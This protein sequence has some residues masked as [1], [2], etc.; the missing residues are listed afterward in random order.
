MTIPPAHALL[1][2]YD[3]H[4][5]TLPWRL[6]DRQTGD[7][8]GTHA[9][10]PYRVW[11]SEI[12][13]QQTT[14]K[15]VIPYYEKF[16]A[17]FPT[18]QALA[19]ADREQV[20][21]AWAGLG[22]YSR[23]RNLHA[24][25]QAV[26]ARGGFPTTVAG[27]QALPGIGAYTAAAVAAI[28]FGVPVVPVDGNVERVTARLFNMADP[29]P[30]ARRTLATLAAG[31]NADPQARARP[32]AFAQALFD[33]GASLCSPRQ[34][35]CGLCPW[36]A[37]CAAHAAGTAASLPRKAPKVARPVRYGVHFLAMDAAGQ[38]LLR[39]R[40]ETG[41]LAAMTEL[42]GTDW[43]PQP[44]PEA[45]A[46]SHA[47]VQAARNTPWQVAGNVRHVFT[48][49]TLELVVYAARLERFSNHDVRDGFLLPLE[50]A[51]GASLPSVMRKCL[52]LGARVLACGTDSAEQAPAPCAPVQHGFAGTGSLLAPSAK[53]G[54]P[55]RGRA[56]SARTQ[57][58][59]SKAGDAEPPAGAAPPEPVPAP[60]S[61]PGPSRRGAAR[62]AASRTGGG[63]HAIRRGAA[64][65]GRRGSPA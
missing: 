21:A 20:L 8:A 32:S 64:R 19:A 39:R 38:V 30:A 10:D 59:P 42:P 51:R 7:G 56:G 35:A 37:N 40:P 50:Q 63:R 58:P 14:V 65:A 28:A 17:L 22:Y 16:L 31:L 23:A 45:E 33:L 12:M 18:V 26:A 36:H 29:L 55:R 1:H 2:W 54:V 11:L 60:V 5:R 25:A 46:L 49:F 4:S 61:T 15:A 53:A 43:R 48:H 47:P 57:V 6:P 27:L 41:L 3:R 52:D 34:P 13:L 24:C 9:P 44:W 62:T